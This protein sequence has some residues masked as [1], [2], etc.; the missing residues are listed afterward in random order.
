MTSTTTNPEKELARRTSGGIDVS[1]YWNKRTNRIT[2][3][4]HS[5]SGETLAFEVD[6]RSALDAYHHPFARPLKRA[7]T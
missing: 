7:T 4:V 2:V 3:K 5:Q 6:R 1:L